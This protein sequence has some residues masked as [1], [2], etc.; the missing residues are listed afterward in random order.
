MPEFFPDDGMHLQAPPV[1][2]STGCL[3]PKFNKHLLQTATSVVGHLAAGACPRTPGPGALWP[4]PLEHGRGALPETP[5]P[6]EALSRAA[7]GPWSPGV[8]GV[9]GTVRG[10]GPRGTEVA[11]AAAGCAGPCGAL[12]RPRG[13]THKHR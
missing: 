8:V 6:R 11:S 9:G 7:C 13:P 12:T 1:A 5:P 3:F 4:D 2:L 10:E